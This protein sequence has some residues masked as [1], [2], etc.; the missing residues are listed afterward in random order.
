[1]NHLIADLINPNI[2]ELMIIVA[3]VIRS[4][5]T[6]TMQMLHA[7][8]YPCAG[9]YPAFEEYPIGR[10]PWK[11]LNVKAVKLVD[12]HR[13][14][15]EDGDYRVIRLHRDMKQQS[16][17]KDYKVID[18]WANRHDCLRLHFEDLILQPHDS[19]LKIAGWVNLPLNVQKMA[20]SVIERSPACHPEILELTMF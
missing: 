3:G 19:A 2:G 15:P 9:E 13:H 14:L 8:G 20:D 1:V 12:A 17:K 4:G 6:L 16:F 5:L 11:N 10:I 7:G 18:R